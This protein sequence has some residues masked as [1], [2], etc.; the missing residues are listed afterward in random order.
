MDRH[1][2]ESNRRENIKIDP[3]K[4]APL[5]FDKDE[6]NK[7]FKGG[8]IAFLNKLCSS[9]LGIFSQKL[10]L[11]LNLQTLHKYYLKMDHRLKCEIKL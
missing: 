2:D 7:K 9:N 11:D 1:T 4:Y 10:N 6:R 3:Q 5:V 8:R